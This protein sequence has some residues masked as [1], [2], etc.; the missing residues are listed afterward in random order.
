MVLSTDLKSK[1]KKL[2][3]EKKYKETV[4]FIKKNIDPIDRSAGILNILG[5][6]KLS[7]KVRTKEILISSIDDFR[8]AFQKDK[9][10]KLGLEIFANF[11]H[12]SVELSDVDN[13]LVNFDEL[14]NLYNNSQN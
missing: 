2:L 1:I 6:S 14:I 4:S 5:V 11:I 12:T 7:E 3:E 8:K 9:S 10:T 13:S